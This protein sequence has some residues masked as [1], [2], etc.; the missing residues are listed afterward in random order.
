MPKKSTRRATPARRRHAKAMT[1]PLAGL[2]AAFKMLS[3]SDHTNIAARMEAEKCYPYA[4]ALIEAVYTDEGD[5]SPS[6]I[7]E[8]ATKAF[9]GHMWSDDEIA[10]S[11]ELTG[12]TALHIGFAACWLLMMEVNGKGGGR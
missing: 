12:H 11:P 8:R 10:H 2:S 6:V 4:L 5:E 3:E 1:P 9:H 7:I